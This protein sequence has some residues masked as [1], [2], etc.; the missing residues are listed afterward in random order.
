MANPSGFLLTISLVLATPIIA[1]STVDASGEHNLS[2][3]PNKSG[4]QGSMAEC[5]GNDEFNVDSEISSRCMLQTTPSISY[6]ALEKN[7]VPCSRRG[8]SNENCQPRAEANPYNRG[9]SEITR[10]RG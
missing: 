7:T 6:G 3:V 4:C 9:C 8:V 5:M 1:L 2:L 10:C